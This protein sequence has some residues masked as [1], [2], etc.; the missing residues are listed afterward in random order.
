MLS[1]SF[2]TLHCSSLPPP[3]LQPCPQ[4]IQKC[5]LRLGEGT[6]WCAAEHAGFRSLGTSHCIKGLPSCFAT[7]SLCL[8]CSAEA[9]HRRQSHGQDLTLYWWFSTF[10]KLKMLLIKLEAPLVRFMA[11]LGKHQRSAFS[12]FLTTDKYKRNP[13]VAK[14]DYNRAEWF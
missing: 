4:P 1:I 8:L 3:H 5:L 12:G 11:H 2:G 10:C 7:A 9:T 13:S 14:K 6:G